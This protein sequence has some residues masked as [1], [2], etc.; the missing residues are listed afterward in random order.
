MLF[1]T[2]LMFLKELILINQVHQKSASFAIIG[3]FLKKELS[4]K[5]M[6][7]IDVTIY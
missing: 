3:I 4:F 5:H 2:K 1:M 6:Y 7:A